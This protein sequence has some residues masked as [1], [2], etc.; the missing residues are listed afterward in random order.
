[1]ERIVADMMVHTTQERLQQLVF[2]VLKRQGGWKREEVGRICNAVMTEVYGHPAH[3]ETII[4]LGEV[5]KD[6]IISA[7]GD[8][9]DFTHMLVQGFDNT[10]LPFRPPGF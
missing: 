5:A 6:S 3:P 4:L 8:L 7:L 9:S 1:M 2:T 10:N